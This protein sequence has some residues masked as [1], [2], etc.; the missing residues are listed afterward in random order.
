MF[1]N[2][3][4]GTVRIGRLARGSELCVSVHRNYEGGVIFQEA[5]SFANSSHV[6]C[7]KPASPQ[8]RP[9]SFPGSWLPCKFLSC[10]NAVACERHRTTDETGSRRGARR[11]ASL[12]PELR[13][14]VGDGL[15]AGARSARTLSETAGGGDSCRTTR[16]KD[17]AT[18][19]TPK[20]GIPLLSINPETLALITLGMLFNSI[21]RSEF[22]EAT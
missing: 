11:T 20:Y 3:C 18:A 22:N 10:N 21:T 12:R 15:Q 5:G 14:P 7:R 19:E 4:S 13:I 6:F 1:M 17:V 16:V 9:M 8:V 2:P